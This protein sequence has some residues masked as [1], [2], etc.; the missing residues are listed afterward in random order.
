MKLDQIQR[1]M[2]NAVRQP[3]TPDE[4]MHT[5]LA[6]GR[7]TMETAQSI[8]K[9]N[10]RLTS[11]E[12]LEIYNRQYWFRLISSMADDFEGVRAILGEKKFQKLVVAY[13]IDC[14]STSFTL[15]N[16]GSKLE[17]WL[18]DHRE[19]VQGVEEISIDMVRLEWAQVEAFDSEARPKL[20]ASELADLGPDPM[21]TLQPYVR[22]LKLKHPVHELSIRVRGRRNQG[23]RTRRIPAKLLPR[24][25]ATFLAVHRVDNSVDFEELDREAFA[26]LAAFQRGCTVSQALDSADWSGHPKEDGGGIVQDYFAKW[27]SVGWFCEAE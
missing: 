10:S 20:S 22:L 18:R 26:I 17:R 27:A 14:P 25:R 11:F 13:L 23:A 8:I 19:H 4:R 12:R 1:T 9:P 21:L 5:N 7:S 3:L 16:L 15:R 24:E 2:F 6:D